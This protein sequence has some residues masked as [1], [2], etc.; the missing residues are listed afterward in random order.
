VS[1]PQAEATEE[2]VNERFGVFIQKRYGLYSSPC[3]V[4]TWKSRKLRWIGYTAKIGDS[5]NIYGVLVRK[6]SWKALIWK[7]TKDK[8]KTDVRETACAELAR[9]ML[10]SMF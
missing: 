6:T 7:S 5:R 1:I 4:R 2:G 9:L 3:V 8:I 10:C